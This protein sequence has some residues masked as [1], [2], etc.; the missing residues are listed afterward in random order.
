MLCWYKF[1]NELNNDNND[2]MCVIRINLF[3]K[4]II[5]KSDVFVI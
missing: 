2:I 4:S 1:K 5:N 3:S